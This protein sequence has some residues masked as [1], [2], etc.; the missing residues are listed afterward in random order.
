MPPTPKN[1]I[2]VGD[3]VL[4]RPEEDVRTHSGL[5]LPRG[6]SEAEGVRSGWVVATGPGVAVPAAQEPD[7][8]EPWKEQRREP[9]YV[10]MQVRTG[11]HALFFK[12]AAIEVRFEGDTY[13]VVPQSAVL[14]VFRDPDASDEV[15]S[16]F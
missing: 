13:L 11:D 2:V 7:A 3:R 16:V 9:R 1:L 15:P 6:V 5:L 8:D 14:V 4:I 12:K 10:P